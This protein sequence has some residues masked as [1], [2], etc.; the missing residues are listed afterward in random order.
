MSTSNLTNDL[1]KNRDLL[2]AF[3]LSLTRDFEASE[4]IFQEVALAIVSEAQKGASI[5]PFMVWARELARRRVA[6]YYRKQAHGKRFEPLSDALVESIVLAHQEHEIPADLDR[7]RL[8]TL[9]E[10]LE[11]LS[12][13]MRQIIDLRY[14][15]K[16]SL[17]GVADQIAWKIGSVKVALTRARQSL[18]ECVQGKTRSE[19]IRG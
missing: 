8:A 19:G 6:E 3:I 17:Q 13:R 12:T 11:R 15:E 1:L 10:C 4:E 16:K 7:Q 18:A 2:F 5:I 9:A 14:R